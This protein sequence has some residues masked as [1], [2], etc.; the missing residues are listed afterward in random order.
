MFSVEQTDELSSDDSLANTDI[1]SSLLMSSRVEVV[2]V[3]VCSLSTPLSVT[4][5]S[6][7]F[8]TSS[9][10]IESSDDGDEELCLKTLSGSLHLKLIRLE[11]FSG[12]IFFS[13]DSFI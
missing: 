3:D 4:R 2:D 12:S 7:L 5:I 13:F 8:S 10:T 9:A 6:S 1:A 11:S